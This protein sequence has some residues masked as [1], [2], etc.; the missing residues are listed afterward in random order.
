MRVTSR[1]QPRPRVRDRG[2]ALATTRRGRCRADVAAANR[3]GPPGARPESE[4]ELLVG[5]GSDLDGRRTLGNA[6]REHL[7][8]EARR[9]LVERLG[10]LG[11]VSRRPQVDPVEG[12]EAE[13]L[14]CLLNEPD[15][16]AYQP[17][18]AQLPRNLAV[19]RDCLA[20]RRSPPP[21][22]SGGS[23]RLRHRRG[24]D[25][26]A[27]RRR[28]PTPS[29]RAG[30][31]P[32]ARRPPPPPPWRRLAPAR[33]TACPAR[34]RAPSAAGWSAGRGR[35][36]GARATD[37][38]PRALLRSWRQTLGPGGGRHGQSSFV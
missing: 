3:S 1:T 25:R 5:V 12:L 33:R 9:P 29:P 28:R 34:V 11:V 2:A 14:T 35:K 10:K 27:R 6:H 16:L 30:R 23:R 18:P 4:L 24:R 37:L 22:R 17:P 31:R 36:G 19:Q 32:A 15:R 8:T 7:L 20:V 21:S 38:P 26:P 13:R